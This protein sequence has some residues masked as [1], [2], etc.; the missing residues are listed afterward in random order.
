MLLHA[1]GVVA[2]DRSGAELRLGARR[3]MLSLPVRFSFKRSPL[4]ALAR[5]AA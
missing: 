5:G 2:V 1:H 4:S 3:V